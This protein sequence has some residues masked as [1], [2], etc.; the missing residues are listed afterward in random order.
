MDAYAYYVVILGLP[1]D[2]FWHADAP[3]VEAV[4]QDK[5]AY[6]AWYANELRRKS[7]RR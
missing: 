6:E 3:F 4:A 1:E 2:T 5:A 7:E